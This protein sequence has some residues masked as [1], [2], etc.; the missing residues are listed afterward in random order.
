MQIKSYLEMEETRRLEGVATNLRDRLLIRMLRRLGCRIS[1]ALAITQADVDFAQGTVVIEHLKTRSRLSCS[2]CGARLG[3]SHSFCPKCGA[4]VDGA[5]AKEQE[6]RKMRTLPLD[7][8]TLEMLR[9]YIELGGPVKQRGKNL[10]FRP[11]YDST[12][13]VDDIEVEGARPPAA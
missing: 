10:I 13:I 5:A 12:L 3:K 1:E 11:I 6:H 8:D 7:R 9:H 4:K 2:E